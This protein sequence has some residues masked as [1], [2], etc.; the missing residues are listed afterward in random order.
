MIGDSS[1][2]MAMARA[3]G[4]LAVGVSWGFQP[5]E[6]LV[7]AGAQRVIARMD[8]VPALADIRGT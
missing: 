6:R 2:D 3:A 1:Y 4:C 7:E 8:E 5:V